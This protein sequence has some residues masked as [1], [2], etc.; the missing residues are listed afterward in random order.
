MTKIIAGS[1]A[2]N[3]WQCN[4]HSRSKGGDKIVRVE[5][6]YTDTVTMDGVG[7]RSGDGVLFNAVADTF[8]FVGSDAGVLKVYYRWPIV[9]EVEEPRWKWRPAHNERSSRHTILMKT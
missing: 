8:V 7:E 5:T 3:Q 2:E 1:I 6:L 4:D 9:R